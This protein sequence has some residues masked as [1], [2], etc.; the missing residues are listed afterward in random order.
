MLNR[1]AVKH[2]GLWFVMMFAGNESVL[3]ID[4]MTVVEGEHEK[5]WC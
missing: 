1:C 5:I 3:V 2:T 4:E